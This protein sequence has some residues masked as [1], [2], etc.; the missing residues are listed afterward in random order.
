MRYVF[1]LGG[2]CTA[3]MSKKQRTVSTSTTEAEYIALGHGARQGVWM[4]RFLNELGLDEAIPNII[5]LGDNKSSIALVQNPEQHSC[6]KHIDVQH[7]YIQNL[8]EDREL[9]VNWVPT[10]KMLADG[11]T[12]TLTKNTFRSHC[13]QL[14]V[15]QLRK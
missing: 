2:A 4:R 13:Q 6:T 3:W 7:H 5:L 10:K 15:V 14:G 9:I 8:V 11:L 12:K 1:M